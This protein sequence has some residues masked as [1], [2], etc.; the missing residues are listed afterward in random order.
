M[1][2]LIRLF[3]FG[4]KTILALVL[5]LVIATAIMS[6]P[7][8]EARTETAPV[9]APTVEPVS[10]FFRDHAEFGRV[11]SVEDITAWAYGERKKVATDRGHYLVYLRADG[12]IQSVLDLDDERKLVWGSYGH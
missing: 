9:A 7:K 1:R 5:L 11:L 4:I 6:K 2:S 3:K 12:T 10:G 8:T